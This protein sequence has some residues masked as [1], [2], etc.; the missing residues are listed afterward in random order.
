MADNDL[1]VVAADSSTKIT[2]SIDRR[3]T[4]HQVALIGEMPDIVPA[5]TGA[6]VVY[7]VTAAAVS[8]LVPPT[9]GADYVRLRAFQT[10]NDGKRLFFR[11]DGVNPAN[12]GTNA[13]GY[14]LHL[15]GMTVKIAT[16]TNFKMIVEFGGGNFTV[17]AEWLLS[18]P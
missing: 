2:R 7:T 5:L 8:P 12:D 18:T 17:T 3:G 6:T 10:A 11:K 16:L 4:H 14:V 1:T 9:A 13:E 15:E